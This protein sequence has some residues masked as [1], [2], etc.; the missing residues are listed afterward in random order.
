MELYAVRIFVRHWP[1]ACAFY[2]GTLGLSERYRNDEV[3]WAEYDLGGPCLG[4]ERVP[5]GDSEGEALVG[6]FV[7]VSLRVDDIDGVYRCL[8]DKGVAF[9]SPPERQPWGGSLAH[10]HDPDGNVLT[11]LG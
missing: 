3:G 9:P 10:F 11:L 6:R 4:I 8:S 2:G 5:V 1:A 7:G